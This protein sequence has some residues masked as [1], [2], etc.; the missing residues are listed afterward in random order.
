MMERFTKP[1]KPN[2]VQRIANW[3]VS[4]NTTCISER[5]G[6]GLPCSTTISHVRILDAEPDVECKPTPEEIPPLIAEL[7]DM[8][9][10]LTS[11]WEAEDSETARLRS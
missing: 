6:S 4:N 7:N 11:K 9:D 5:A 10:A 8:Y 3:L 2:P 1:S